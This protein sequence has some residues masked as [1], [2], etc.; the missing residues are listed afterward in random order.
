MTLW[1]FLVLTLG[2]RARSEAGTQ[3]ELVT[4]SKGGKRFVL[5]FFIFSFY[6]AICT[7]KKCIGP[8]VLLAF[9]CFL[10]RDKATWQRD[11]AV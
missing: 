5:L 8:I 3:L 6:P 11:E 1:V 7:Y 2:H 4:F 9:R 10:R